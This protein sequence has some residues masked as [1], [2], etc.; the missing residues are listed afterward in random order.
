MNKRTD[1]AMNKKKSNNLYFDIEAELPPSPGYHFE[2][3]DYR[4]CL[5]DED[6]IVQLFIDQR[7]EQKRE[8]NNKKTKTCK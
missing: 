4:F 6:E 5:V 7:E 3:H 8:E 2:Y 1:Q